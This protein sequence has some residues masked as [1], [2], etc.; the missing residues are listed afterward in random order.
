MASSS[1]GEGLAALKA[2]LLK[3]AYKEQ[4]ST[5]SDVAAY[6]RKCYPSLETQLVEIA[7]SLTF[8]LARVFFFS[9]TNSEGAPP[10]APTLSAMSTMCAF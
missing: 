4:L 2:H 3:G 10:L 9:A 6:V 1:G 8:F 7:S 5:L